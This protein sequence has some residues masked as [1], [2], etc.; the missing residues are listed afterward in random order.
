MAKRMIM[1]NSTDSGIQETTSAPVEESISAKDS[2][3]R[4]NNIADTDA[5]DRYAHM[6]ADWD[7]LPPQILVRRV[8]R[9]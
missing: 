3:I 1:D 7:L 5:E 2:L 4:E 9:K 8:N 6:F